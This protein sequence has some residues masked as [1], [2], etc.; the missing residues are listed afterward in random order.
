[1]N[2][3]RG[4]TFTQATATARATG[5]ADLVVRTKYTLVNEDAKGF[6]AAADVRLPTGRREDLLGAGTTSMKVSGIGSVERGATAANA[7][8]GVSFGGLS[9]E[10]S[11]GGAVTYAASGRVSVVGELLGRW[12]DRRGPHH[13]GV[14][15][16]S[17]ALGGADD[18]SDA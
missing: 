14:G 4:R 10:M 13:S 7:N 12:F 16:A 1:M 6:A 17:A 3:Y 18:S 2:T 5:F 15:A 9:N 11:Y 8:A